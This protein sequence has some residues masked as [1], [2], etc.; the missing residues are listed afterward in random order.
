MKIKYFVS[1]AVATLAILISSTSCVNETCQGPMDYPFL[2]H[3]DVIDSPI[4][5]EGKV[6]N[7]Y[8]TPERYAAAWEIL[9]VEGDESHVIAA[10]ASPT[11]VTISA[12]ATGKERMV[13]IKARPNG[14]ERWL[15]ITNA[16]QQK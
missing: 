5:Q 15:F 7:V 6:V 12:N 2:A 3:S 1:L 14:Q 16:I 9:V 10:S 11:A 13:E 8:V 4:P